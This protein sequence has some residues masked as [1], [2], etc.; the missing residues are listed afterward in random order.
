[1]KTKRVASLTKLYED[2]S[3]ALAEYG[4]W[5]YSDARREAVDTE[6]AILAE[7]L[8]G[9]DPVVPNAVLLRLL[10]NLIED[11]NLRDIKPAG[12]RLAINKLIDLIDPPRGELKRTG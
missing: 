12:M 6:M 10:A 9:Y 1:M 3:V 4:R 11:A 8:R 2:A 5:P 7:A